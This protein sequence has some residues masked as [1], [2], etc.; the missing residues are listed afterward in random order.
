M[1][2]QPLIPG[3]TLTLGGREFVVPPLSMKALRELHPQWPTLQSMGDVPTG[4]Q[5]DV[6]LGVVHSALI[7]N[8]PDL[9]RDE[10][11]ELVDLGNLPKALMAVMGASPEAGK[12]METLH[13]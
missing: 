4:P 6:V 3:V 7:R 5:I 2:D 10:L 9:T 12:I 13:G 8:Y 1:A 11:E